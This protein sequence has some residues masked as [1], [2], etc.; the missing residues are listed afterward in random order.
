MWSGRIGGMLVVAGGLL[1]AI[2]LVIHLRGGGVGFGGGDVSGLVVDASLALETLVPLIFGAALLGSLGTGLAL[3]RT[4]GPSQPVG[5][6]FLVGV[7]LVVLATTLSNSGMWALPPH[8]I[9]AA[10]VV[11]VLGN[12]GV[13]V[14]AINS[15]RSALVDSV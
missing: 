7:V 11:A 3:V 4:P 5:S 9:L 10:I 1:F 8:A 6:L 13:G 2:A 15:S 12:I 14:L